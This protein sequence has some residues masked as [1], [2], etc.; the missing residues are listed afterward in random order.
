MFQPLD[1]KEVRSCVS[2]MLIKH[3]KK[4]DSPIE[5]GDGYGV[6]RLNMRSKMAQQIMIQFA[7]WQEDEK[8]EAKEK[9]CDTSLSLF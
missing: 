8:P 5:K 2:Q 4:S 7:D 9:E 3:S 6:Y 1:Y